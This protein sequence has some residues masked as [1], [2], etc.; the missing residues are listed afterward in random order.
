MR[1][2][3]FFTP[4]CIHGE[5]AFT[6]KQG[7]SSSDLTVAGLTEDEIL[8]PQFRD[9]GVFGKAAEEFAHQFV[10]P[11]L[12]DGIKVVLSI[13]AGFDQPGHSQQCEMVTDGRLALSKPLAQRRDVQFPFTTEEEQDL[14][15]SFVSQQFEDLDQV[16]FQLLRK[17]G[18]TDVPISCRT[19]G[20]LRVPF[21]HRIGKLRNHFGFLLF[22]AGGRAVAPI[23]TGLFLPYRAGLVFV[24]KAP[25]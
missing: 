19:G 20:R 12:L 25:A 8:K 22:I 10:E 16:F 3:E 23:G 5:P 11:M 21:R 9:V 13:A 24:Q 17:F 7:T 2:A 4:R 15:P 6:G 1:L 18:E 14:Q